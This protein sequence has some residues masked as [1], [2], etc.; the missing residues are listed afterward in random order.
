MSL[1]DEGK[2]PF[3]NVFRLGRWIWQHNPETYAQEQFAAAL[4]NLQIGAP[5]ENTNLPKGHVYQD[6][7]VEGEL[8][9][10]DTGV[11][12]DLLSNGDWSC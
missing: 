4:E 7:D 1:L 5:F 3:E 2:N 12:P 9:K 6:W 10:Q 11:L 8:Q